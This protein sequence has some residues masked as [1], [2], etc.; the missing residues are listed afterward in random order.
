MKIPNSA[1]IRA[2][3]LKILAIQKHGLRPADLR[4]LTEQAL[5]HVIPKDSSRRGSYRSAIWDLDKRFPHYVVKQETRNH[6]IFVS[7]N[8]LIHEAKSIEVPVQVKNEEDSLVTTVSD[9]YLQY[10]QNLL[11]VFETID[12]LKLEKFI[13]SEELIKTIGFEE[14]KFLTRA[15]LHLEALRE[16]KSSYLFKSNGR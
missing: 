1:I 8:Q 12:Y 6:A 10:K 4:N 9:E 5:H 3:A 13:P 7:T 15:S 11:R 14:Y 16:L 2:Q